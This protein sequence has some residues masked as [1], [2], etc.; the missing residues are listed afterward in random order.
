LVS[1]IILILL[2]RRWVVYLTFFL[3]IDVNVRLQRWK[4]QPRISSS[5]SNRRE[6]LQSR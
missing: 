5:K 2:C 1:I 4:R 3:C 6:R